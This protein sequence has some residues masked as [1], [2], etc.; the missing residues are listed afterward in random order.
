MTTVYLCTGKDC[1]RSS[2]HEEL[3]GS[4]A[5]DL[6][7]EVRC[8][9]ICKGPVAGLEVDGRLEWFR[10]LRKAKA[11]KALGRLVIALQQ[12]RAELEPQTIISQLQAEM[13]D[14]LESRPLLVDLLAFV[15]RKAPEADVRTA[16]EVLGARLK[17]QRFG[18]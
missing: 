2:G 1:R 5:G 12:M 13:P 6:V 3:A 17:N 7:V 11:R 15:E 4:L 14:F 16:A 10:S 8:Q 18:A 9:K